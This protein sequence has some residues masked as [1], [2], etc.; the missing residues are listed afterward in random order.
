MLTPEY[1]NLLEFN[2]VVQLY[3]KLNIDLTADI[4]DRISAMEDISETAKNEM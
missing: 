3:N 2:D 4:I 1:I